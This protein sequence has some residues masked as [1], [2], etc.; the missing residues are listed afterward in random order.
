MKREAEPLG[1]VK[2]LDAQL[3]AD[4]SKTS[5]IALCILDSDLH[6]QFVNSAMVA[7]HNSVPT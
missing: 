5:V 2:D 4:L 6:Y 7:M 3:I 1:A